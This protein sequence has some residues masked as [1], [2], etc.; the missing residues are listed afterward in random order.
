MA[1]YRRVA[2]TRG[3]GRK[4]RGRGRLGRLPVGRIERA[5]AEAEELRLACQQNNP[6][7]L[8]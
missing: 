8:G 2:T 4:E 5:L 1:A 3:I 6:T 7:I